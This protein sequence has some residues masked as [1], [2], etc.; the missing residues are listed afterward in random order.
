MQNFRPKSGIF[1]PN[2]NIS[3]RDWKERKRSFLRKNWESIWNPV[4][5]L[6]F[7][8][9]RFILSPEIRW[10]RIIQIHYIFNIISG[11][12]F[13]ILFIQ[14]HSDKAFHGNNIYM[15]QEQVF[16]LINKCT[17]MFSTRGW[18]KWKWESSI[19]R[20]SYCSIGWTCETVPMR[21]QIVGNFQAGWIKTIP[22][23]NLK[24]QE[25]ENARQ[26]PGIKLSVT[27]PVC[28]P[29]NNFKFTGI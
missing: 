3:A 1:H 28:G 10:D 9:M 27:F 23:W 18:K 29:E 11:T 26:G 2:E 12:D 14:T 21:V 5:V 17:S 19:N 16:N 13:F 22:G 6:D 4:C 15:S 8:I 24:Y 20:N 7:Q 25:V